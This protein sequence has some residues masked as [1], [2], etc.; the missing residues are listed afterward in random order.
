MPDRSRPIRALK[1]GG[2]PALITAGIGIGATGV[3]GEGIES[4]TYPIAASL[5]DFIGIAPRLGPI[6]VVAIAVCILP[7]A[8]VVP[9]LFEDHSSH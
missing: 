4:Q 3:A 9:G 5:A 6:A 8:L 7:V 1:A 2:P